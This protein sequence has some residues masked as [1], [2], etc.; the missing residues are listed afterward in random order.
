MNILLKV[1]YMGTNY[2]GF[3]MQPS[4]VSIEE[5]LKKQLKNQ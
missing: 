3:Q 2:H 4:C 1:A 5:E